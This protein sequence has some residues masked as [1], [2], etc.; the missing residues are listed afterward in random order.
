MRLSI[1]FTLISLTV[2]ACGGDDGDVLPDANNDIGFNPPTVTLK[3]NMEV[4]ED[5][6]M[7]IGDA[8][9]SCLDTPSSD[10]PN[11]VAVTLNTKVTDFQSGSPVP[12]STVIAFPNQDQGNPFDTQTS[13]S[14][15]DI[16]F[17]IPV[18]TKRFGY[19]MTSSNALPTLLLNQKLA[20]PTTA[21]QTE[22][23]I[24]SVSNATAATLPALI[25]QTRIQGTGVVAGALRDCQNLEVS[26]FI[27]TMSSTPTTASPMEGAEAYY[28]SSGVGLPVHHNQQ[29]AASEDALFMIIQVPTTA[30]TGYVQM[31]GYP[32]AADLAQGMAGLKLIAELQ[33]PIFGDTVITGSYEPVRTN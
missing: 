24:Q 9:L 23:K 33:V 25:G 18:G 10:V 3:A 31:W 8:D 4:A 22:A 11:T 5:S 21:V 30:A 12:S 27:A 32:T 2:T 6:W 7:E 13:D 16:T 1:A 17:T 29:Q 28:F 14:N 15:A 20:S 26:G 19:K